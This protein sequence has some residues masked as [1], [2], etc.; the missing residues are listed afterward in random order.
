MQ[1]TTH[2]HCLRCGR[3]LRTARS[4][5][6]GY[7]P[8]CARHIRRA[9]VQLTDYKAH[10]IASARELIEDGAIIPLKSV[11][12]IAVSTDGTETYKTAPTGCTCPAGLKGARCYHQL[13]ARMLL[14]A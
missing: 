6:T 14:A 13:A 11:V 3:P 1:N 7:G 10:Q 9:A 12:F 8:T 5:A 4:Q 2:T